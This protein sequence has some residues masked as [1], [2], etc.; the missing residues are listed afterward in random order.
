MNSPVFCTIVTPD[1]YPAARAQFESLKQ[2]D[3]TVT[4][5]VFISSGEK[6]PSDGPGSITAGIELHSISE[7]CSSGIGKQIREKYEKDSGSRFR[8]AMKPVILKYLLLELKIPRVVYIDWDIFFYSDYS[9]LF[10]YLLTDSVVLTPQWNAMRTRYNLATLVNAY[11]AGFVGVNQSAIGLMDWWAGECL[12]KCEVDF[13]EGY[14]VDQSY[15]HYF[16]MHDGITVKVVRHRGCNVADWNRE[17]CRRTLVNGEV[18]INE[19]YPVVFVHY[20]YVTIAM[21][22]NGRD[23]LL[24]PHFDRFNELVGKF[25]NGK[26]LIDFPAYRKLINPPGYLQR[27]FDTLSEKIRW[28]KRWHAFI[29][30]IG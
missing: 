28:K 2:F 12:F 5:H 29:R 1:Y 23:G 11:N 6:L 26:K 15:L 21:I 18:L 25:N 9:F 8:W 4:Y 13:L 30:G 7:V 24:R 10:D 27:L 22:L 17:R 14:Y 3:S 20:T 19:Q 16:H